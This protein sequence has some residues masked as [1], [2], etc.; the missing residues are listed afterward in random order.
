LAT[1]RNFSDTL[2][3]KRRKKLTPT[4]PRCDIIDASKSQSQKHQ[5]TRRHP[6]HEHL[7]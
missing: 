5:S 2:K 3:L 7:K 6:V 1:G 4:L